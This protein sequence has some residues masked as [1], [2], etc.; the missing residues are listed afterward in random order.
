MTA[1]QDLLLG[2]GAS[3][4]VTFEPEVDSGTLASEGGSLAL[5]ISETQAV[6]SIDGKARG[7]YAGSFKLPKGPHQLLVERGGF[8]PTDRSVSVDRGECRLKQP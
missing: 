3:G 2:D 4:D 1:Q 8:E 6:V 5:E 7:V